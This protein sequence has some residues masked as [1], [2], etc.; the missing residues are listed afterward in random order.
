VVINNLNIDWAKRALW[1][2]KTNSSLLIDPNAV[3]ALAIT[4]Q[5]F[6]PV[7]GQIQV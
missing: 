7:A 5:C 2:F 3:L 1:P 6:Q 4:F